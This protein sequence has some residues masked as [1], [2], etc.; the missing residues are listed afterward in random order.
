MSTQDGLP[1]TDYATI[2]DGPWMAGIWQGAYPSFQPIY[3]KIPAGKGGS[4]SVVGGEDIVL[5]AS[6]K[7]KA[8]AEKFIAFTQTAKFQLAMAKTGQMTVVPGYAAQQA[9][10]AAYYA[11]YS[12]QLKTAKSRIASPN[13]SKIDTVLGNT[14]TPAFLGTTTVKAALDSAASQIDAL[15]AGN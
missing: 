14:L 15:L 2:F 3:S 5:T 7:H 6:S 12:T 10:I 1:K 9:K 13:Q 11:V 8:A 4:I